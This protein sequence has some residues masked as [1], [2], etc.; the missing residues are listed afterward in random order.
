MDPEYRSER[1]PTARR[2]CAVPGASEHFGK[3]ATLS[4]HGC[5][6]S[7][8]IRRCRWRATSS[9]TPISPTSARCSSR[10]CSGPRGDTGRRWSTRTRWAV[11][12]LVATRR[13]RAPRARPVGTSSDE[14]ADERP[15]TPGPDRRRVHA[16]PPAAGARSTI[17]GALLAGLARRARGRRRI[18]LADLYQSGQHYVEAR[19]GRAPRG[20]PRGC[21]PG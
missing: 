16:L 6:S 4:R 7:S 8:F 2:A 18:V 3:A 17:L 13:P 1:A 19:R 20:L 9:T 10:R 14:A 21:A 11:A 15:R 5:A 12:A